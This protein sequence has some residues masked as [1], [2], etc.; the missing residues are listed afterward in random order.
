MPVSALEVLKQMNCLWAMS[1]MISKWACGTALEFGHDL[2]LIGG[3]DLD[4]LRRN[5]RRLQR[6]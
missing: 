1:V 3:I 6:N 5:K 4:A 2:S